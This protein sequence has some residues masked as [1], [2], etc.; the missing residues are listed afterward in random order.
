ML[1]VLDRPA[2]QDRYTNEAQRIRRSPLLGLWFLPLSCFHSWHIGRKSRHPDRIQY[3]R[4]GR[5]LKAV[6]LTVPAE[7]VMKR[8]PVSRRQ[9]IT[10]AAVAAGSAFFPKQLL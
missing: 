8:L 6:R 10:S 1:L 5:P 3:P 4:K 9:F 7:F 2:Q